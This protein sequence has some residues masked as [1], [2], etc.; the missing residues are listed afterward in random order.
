[1]IWRTPEYADYNFTA[2]PALEEMFGAGFTDRLQ[3]VLLDLRDP[4][5]L[6]AFRR[7]RLIAADNADFA[8]VATEYSNGPEAAAGGDI[9]WQVSDLLDDETFLALTAIGVGET[10]EP[11]DG[12]DGY[13]IYQKQEEA[14]RPL[15]DEDAANVAATAFGEW[16]DERYFAATDDGTISIDESVY[17]Q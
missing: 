12:G 15:E 6:A 2:H 7:K 17:E 13:R 8:Q 1:M 11:V 16:Y 9:G 5:L 4:E 10:T 3:R 14:Q